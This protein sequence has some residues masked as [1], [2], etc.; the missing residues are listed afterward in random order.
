MKDEKTLLVLTELLYGYCEAGFSLKTAVSEL[1]DRRTCGKVPLKVHLCCQ[2][3]KN[4]LSEGKKA[5]EAFEKLSCIKVPSWFSGFIY[6]AEEN[7]SLIKTLGFLK[8][9]LEERLNRF[10]KTFLS[11]LYP[12][13]VCSLSFVFSLVFYLTAGAKGGGVKGFF[14]TGE[15]SVLFLGVFCAGTALL[16][17]H[18]FSPSVPPLLFKVLSFSVEN[19]FTLAGALD[20]VFLMFRGN[21]K[22]EGMILKIRR[23]IREGEKV[24][25]VFCSAL[26]ECGFDFASRTAG[27]CLCLSEASG[28]YACFEKTFRIL[29]QKKQKKEEVFLTLLNPFLM[30]GICFYLYLLFKDTLVP[31][32][33]GASFVW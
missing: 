2:E 19:G 30:C 29:N 14:L 20:C 17:K 18:I 27:L 4:F 25:E 6:S 28:D 7:G 3:L 32:L 8:K 26:K 9:M 21:E 24:A 1:S 11:L 5:G 10:E 31:V 33:G 16:V 23:R 15:S 13:C 12:V 22:I